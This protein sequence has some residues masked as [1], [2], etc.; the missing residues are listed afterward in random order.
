MA[1][2]PK[3][4]RPCPYKSNLAAIID[5][6][7]CRMCDRQVFDLT[8]MSDGERVAF[9]SGCTGEVCV[10]YRLRPALAAAAF[11]A[12][13][14]AFPTAAAAQDQA[15]AEQAAA[16][17][18]ALEEASPGEYSVIMVGGIKDPANV[19]YVETDADRAMAELPVVYEDAGDVRAAVAA[20]SAADPPPAVRVKD[21]AS[22]TSPVRS[23]VG[24]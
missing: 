1:V 19:E 7:M 15:G 5:G 8:H 13:A 11:A 23:P 18:S 10:S 16:V 12:T 14:F 22:P 2:F 3:I 20:S 9:L 21:A 17:A 24:S 6:D 4:Q